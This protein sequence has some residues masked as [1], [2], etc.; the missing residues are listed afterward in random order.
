[1]ALTNQATTW[2][3]FW[4]Y[5]SLEAWTLLGFLL[6]L[7]YPTLLYV[8]AAI[9]MPIDANADTDWR[10][11][12]FS[13]RATLFGLMSVQIAVNLL[14]FLVV[15]DV[16]LL[17]PPIY[18]STVFAGMYL[19]GLYTDQPRAHSVLVVAN[20]VLIVGAIFPLAYRPI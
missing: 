10:A 18:L 14:T 2:W 13:I 3:L 4:N 8:G 20:A 1:M 15:G 17:S 19:Y 12:F 11:Y 7:L 5:R 6:V 9:L 16:P